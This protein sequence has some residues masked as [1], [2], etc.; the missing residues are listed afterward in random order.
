[1]FGYYLELAMRSM[2]RNRVLTAL[3]VV[4]VAL[5]I[6]SCMTT[7]TVLH[8]LSG[9]PM[10]GKSQNLYTPQIDPRAMDGYVEDGPM[11]DQ[12]TWIDGMNLLRSKRGEHQALMTGGAMTVQPSDGSIDPFYANSRYTTADFFPMFAIPLLYGRAWN[13]SD[14]E[15]RT[16]VAVI[17]SELNDKLFHGE[18]ST[19][20]SIRIHGTDMRIVGVIG[21][22]RPTP[23]FYD[24]NMGDFANT[25][26]VFVPL[27]VARELL[28]PRSGS[29]DC[30]GPGGSA[31]E[32]LEK[33][34]CVWLQFW[35]QLDSPAKAAEY[36]QFLLHYVQEQKALGRFERPARVELF[37]VMQW[38]DYKQVVPGDVKLQTLLAMGFFLVCLVNTVG[39]MLAKFMRRSVEVG[40]RRALGA[41]RRA[42]F[43]QLLTE[44]GIIGLMGGL[45][46]L[47]LAM[48]GLVLVRAQPAQYASLAHLD[49]EMLVL[50]MVLAI[51]ATVLAGVLP[52]W[53]ACQIAPALQLKTQ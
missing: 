6:G 11:L 41:S 25:E 4:A 53:R 1:M 26:D 38:M 47:M 48:A 37:N 31:E 40:V 14:D 15:A 20:K 49:M 28:L 45:L 21:D 39:L 46:G 13:A 32:S 44:A 50:T 16:R 35:V 27:S 33:A 42:V 51:V 29:I 30:W 17:S 22:W 10:P 34:S 9:D 24:L 19:G 8:V 52:A 5:G 3:M 43:A 7:L 2:K 18:D 23:H 12:V 36:R